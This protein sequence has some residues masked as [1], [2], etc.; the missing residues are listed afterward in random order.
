VPGLARIFRFLPFLLAAAILLTLSPQSSV[1]GQ[2]G[3]TGSGGDLVLVAD[4]TGAIG[5]A[6]VQFVEKAIETASERQADLLVLRMNTPG[7]LVTSMRDMIEDIIASPV[8]IAG[9]VAPPGARAASAGTFIIYATHVAAMA[10][11]TNLGAA[12]PIQMGGAPQLPSPGGD[13]S[14][15]NTG[16]GEESG[17]GGE[18]GESEQQTT[19][20]EPAKAKALNDAIAFIRSLAEL[21][22]RNAEWAEKAVRQAATLSAEAARQENV[23]DF[24]AADLEALLLAVDGRTVTVGNSERTLSTA[25]ARVEQLEPSVINEILALITNPNVALILMMIGV[26]GLIFEF[27]NP[28]TIGPG[29]IGVIC[30]ILGLYSLN[31]LPLDYAGLALITLGVIF[32]TVE[33]VTPAFGVFGVGGLVAFVIGATMLV[34]TE[35]PAYQLSWSV[36]GGITIASG[37]ILILVVGYV[38]RAYRHPVVIGKDQFRGQNAEVLEWSGHEGQVWLYGERW[39]ASS[40]QP[41]NEGDTVRVKKVDGMRLLVERAPADGAAR[42]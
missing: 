19:P 24:V 21:R 15:D 34:D 1:H 31:Q 8:P 28:G 3:S 17:N 27:A 5:P 37:A 16:D 41:L 33:A 12:T 39:L 6:S 13:G 40:E 30:L 38:W 4:V 11:G 32:M 10:P 20:E 22:G 25:D 26:Y 29:V 9:Y 18:E 7:G 35:V 23:V 42:G 2:Q 14:D 36:I